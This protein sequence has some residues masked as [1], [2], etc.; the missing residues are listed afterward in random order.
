[1]GD[2]DGLKASAQWRESER[3]R[4]FGSPTDPT[5]VAGVKSPNEDAELGKPP[6]AEV[7]CPSEAPDGTIWSK[8]DIDVLG[9][10]ARLL[11]RVEERHMSLVKSTISPAMLPYAVA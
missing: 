8:D 6:R 11:A 4:S 2:S 7:G 9:V 3:S 1:M 10:P 5:S